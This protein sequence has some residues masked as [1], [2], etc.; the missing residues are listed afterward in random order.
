M[1]AELFLPDLFSE[2]GPRWHEVNN[3]KV[4]SLLHVLHTYYFIAK[5]DVC[6][7]KQS[8]TIELN[9][10][11]FLILTNKN[12]YVV[13]RWPIDH[14]QNNL[15]W[16]INANLENWLADQ[17]IHVPTIL[18]S[19]SNEK[20]IVEYMGCYWCVNYFS[21]IGSELQEAGLEICKLFSSLERVSPHLQPINVVKS[22][23]E[24]LATMIVDL[25]RS[26]CDWGAIFGEQYVDIFND[27]WSDIKAELKRLLV[28]QTSLPLTV[29]ICHIDMHPHNIL[30]LN[31]KV[32][33][34]LDYHSLVMAQRE[35]ILA[36]NIF[37]LA[38]QAMV[39]IGSKR[40]DKDIDGQ[41]VLIIRKLIEKGV[42]DEKFYERVSIYAKMEIMR[43]LLLIMELNIKDKNQEWNH[44]LQV[45]ISALKEVDV[46]FSS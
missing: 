11:N 25:E 13:K 3:E 41:V 33:A 12:K 8:D 36:F 26:Q 20:C 17:N 7:I 38:R 16:E 46:I 32:S 43:R 19:E 31:G 1:R 37:K 39:I 4:H 6:S 40:K 23:D 5:E 10:N 44:I 34:I 2:T 27:S 14:G 24:N 30:M 21:G 45:Q 22:L 9:S 15:N 29:G 35:P 28:E 42:V 18:Q